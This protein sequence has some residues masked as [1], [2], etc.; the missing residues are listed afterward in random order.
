[1]KTVA[2]IGGT[3]TNTFKRIGGKRGFLISYVGLNL[4]RCWTEQILLEQGVMIVDRI[5]YGLVPTRNWA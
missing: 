5:H 2:I 4:P 1:M 3:Q